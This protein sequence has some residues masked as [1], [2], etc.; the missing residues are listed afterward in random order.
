MGLPD[1]FYEPGTSG[2]YQP[3]GHAAGPWDPGFQHGG[4]PAALLMRAIEGQLAAEDGL[5]VGRVTYEILSP[6]PMRPLTV[7]ARVARPGRRVRRIEAELSAEGRAVMTVSAWAIRPAPCEVRP[8][9]A[10]D[11]DGPGTGAPP[12]GPEGLPVTDPSAHPA[13]SC[14]FLAATEWR[15]TSGS[16]LVPGPATAWVRA[17]VPLLPGEQLSPLQRTVLTADSANGVS[18]VLDIADWSFI[19]PELTVHMLRPP[20]GEWLCMAA[21]SDVRPGAVGLAT[22]T[23]HDRHGLVARSAQALLISAR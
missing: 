15:F 23:L 13:W 2:S 3:T 12:R 21:T 9:A 11:A 17:R 20:D 16:Y 18:G 6:V 22:A 5:R 10:G 8:G 14:G 1:A 19:P 7:T 4:P